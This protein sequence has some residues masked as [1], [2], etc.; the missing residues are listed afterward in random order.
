MKN[1]RSERHRSALETS[2]QLRCGHED[3]GGDDASAV[4]EGVTSGAWRGRYL[5]GGGASLDVVSNNSPE[6]VEG[7][8]EECPSPVVIQRTD[9]ATGEVD[10]IEKACGRRSCPYCREWLRRAE[11]AHFIEVY[12]DREDVKFTTLTLDPKAF[13]ESVGIDPQDFEQTRRYLLHVWERKFIKR[14]KRRVE[15]D[16][17]YTASIEE[18]ESGRAHIHIVWSCSLSEE[19]IRHHWFESGGGVVME[20]VGIADGEDLARQVGY[21]LKYA[22]KGAET[23]KKGRNAIFNSEGIGFHSEEAKAKRRE[24]VQSSAEDCEEDQND[25]RYEYSGP[26][27]GGKTDNGDTITEEQ[28][29]RFDGISDKARSSTY[30][31]WE[32]SDPPREGVRYSYDRESGQTER[33]RVRQVITDNGEI[34]LVTV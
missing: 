26:S 1:T 15:G 6:P 16:F 25:G 22:F 19:Q 24:R 9:R 8:Y 10:T 14:I 13:P 30:V 31:D 20:S 17:A 32:S 29:R 11:T 21:V 33:T 23:R 5:S 3:K 2:K 34:E 4:G 28:R 7:D 18:H 12:E 27:G